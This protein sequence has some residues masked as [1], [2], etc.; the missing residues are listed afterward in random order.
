MKISVSFLG[1]KN[2]YNIINEIDKTDAD[3]IHVDVMDGKYVPNKAVSNSEASKISH[4]SKKRLDVH[5][6]V[7][8]PL[9][10]IDLYA[11]Y[12]VE[13]ITFHLNT[14]D[15]IDD[16]ISK[17][18]SYGIKVGLSVNPNED[19]EKVFPY[20]NKIDLVLIMTVVPGLPGQEL[21]NDVIPK[22]KTLKKK[23]TDQKVNVKISVDGGINLENKKLV[24]LSDI[25][26]SGSCVTKSENF[27][28]A[29][30]ELRNN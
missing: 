27:Q 26:V 1:N 14:L 3:Y 9:K 15:N 17:C 30:T 25:I 10:Y 24:K 28:K 7:E 22:I 20:L 11:D 4:Y 13:F 12:N 2:I 29:I 19:I 16:V 23:I 8:S 6:M 18:H 5:L 21:I